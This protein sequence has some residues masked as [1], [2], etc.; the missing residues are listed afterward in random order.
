MTLTAKQEM[1]VVDLSEASTG[2]ARRRR[3]SRRAGALLWRELGWAPSSAR[4]SSSRVTICSLG[5][6]TPKVLDLLDERKIRLR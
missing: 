3:I 6:S 5:N 1:W 2:L 4:R